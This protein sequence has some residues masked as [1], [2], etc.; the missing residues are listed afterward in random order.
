M[1]I[2]MLCLIVFSIV[3]IVNVLVGLFEWSAIVDSITNY[4][5]NLN[6]YIL[7]AILFLILV[8]ALIILIFEFYRKKIKI[9]NITSN[10]S[11]KAMVS[12][13]TVSSQIEEKLIGIEDILDP[14]VKIVPMRRGIIINTSSKLIKGVNVTKKTKEIRHT[15]SEFASKNLGF[16]VMKSNYTVVELISPEILTLNKFFGIKKEHEISVEGKE[17]KNIFEETETHMLEVENK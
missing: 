17:S 11:G 6:P 7:V 5:T 10:K 15:A 3:A 9:V 8:I 2:L 4:K 13:K 12:L 14:K 16:R 1:A